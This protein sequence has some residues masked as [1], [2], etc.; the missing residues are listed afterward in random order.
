VTPKTRGEKR[1]HAIVVQFRSSRGV[2]S[3]N[4]SKPGK[5][6]FGS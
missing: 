5:V 6:R 2:P 3:E 4:E 1:K